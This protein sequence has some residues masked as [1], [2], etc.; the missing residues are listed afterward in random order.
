MLQSFNLSI[1]PPFH[2]SIFP[3]FHLSIF[4]SFH[5]ST[6]P[7]FHLSILSFNRLHMQT[8]FP[9]IGL[10][11]PE[12][13]LPKTGTDL[14]KRAVV[15]CDQYTSQPEYRKQVEELTANIPSTYHITFPE[16]YL[17]EPGKQERIQNIQTYMNSYL[18]E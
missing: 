17:E 3:P 12:I 14:E 4:P 13:Y 8:F 6:F 11:V 10:K 15:A 18:N 16:I 2:L 1:F 5:L 9:E 7:P